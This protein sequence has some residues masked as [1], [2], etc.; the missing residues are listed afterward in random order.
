M[1]STERTERTEWTGRGEERAGG[2]G[3]GAAGRVIVG[4]SGSLASLAALRAGAAEAERG[5]LRLVAVVAWE[6]PEGE[7]LYL[8]HPDPEWARHWQGEARARLD[9]AFDQVFG[10][11]P[12]GIGTVERLVVRDRP[13]RA[14]CA[15]ASRPDDLLVLGAR[16]GRARGTRIHRHV[17]AHAGCAVLT[18]PAPP[19][20]KGLRRALR[21]VTA[22]D[23]AL[24]SGAASDQAA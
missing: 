2:A 11:A 7:A 16:Q 1:E 21:R 3:G 20:P 14:L 15:L 24:V 12:A 4:V 6:P 10:G 17:R 22:E 13:G 9:R 18:V 8:R 19:V 5:G 23:F